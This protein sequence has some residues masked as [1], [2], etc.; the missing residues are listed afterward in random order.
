MFQNGIET[1]ELEECIELLVAEQVREPHFI[2][3][4]HLAEGNLLKTEP[5]WLHFCV[6]M[7][8]VGKQSANE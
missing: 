3:R 6:N 1:S 8:E 7:I 5:L 2:I 4:P